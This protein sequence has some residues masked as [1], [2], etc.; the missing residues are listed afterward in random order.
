MTST[1]HAFNT[2]GLPREQLYLAD[3]HESTLF[4]LFFHLVMPIDSCGFFV[5][6]D[7]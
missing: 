3:S 7:K 4:F 2:F 6:I 5:V 1:D